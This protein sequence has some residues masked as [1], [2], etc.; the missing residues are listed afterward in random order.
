MNYFSFWFILLFPVTVWSQTHFV[1]FLPE[2]S[3]LAVSG[4]EAE[5]LLVFRVE[6]GYHI[7]ADLDQVEDINLIPAELTLGT[8][9]GLTICQVTYPRSKRLWLDGTERIQVFDKVF[10]IRGE[11]EVAGEVPLGKYRVAGALYYQACDARK[12]FFPRTLEF[13]LEMKD[14]GH[15][16]PT[17]FSTES[18]S[19]LPIQKPASSFN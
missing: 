12:C 16:S 18:N 13:D 14:E 3:K 2:Q 9:E 6:S 15:L 7:Q 17:S 19:S 11:A 4:I 8:T 1:S 5:L 10:T